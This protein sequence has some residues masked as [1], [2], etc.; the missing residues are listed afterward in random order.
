M[1]ERNSGSKGGSG[2]SHGCVPRTAGDRWGGRKS[3]KK[4]WILGSRREGGRRPI[5]LQ[6]KD[7]EMRSGCDSSWNPSSGY[8]ENVGC[9]RTWSSCHWDSEGF[10]PQ[11]CTSIHDP[12]TL[13]HSLL[14]SGS[15]CSGGCTDQYTTPLPA[16]GKT[17]PVKWCRV[18]VWSMRREQ[19]PV[20]LLWAGYPPLPRDWGWFNIFQLFHF[21]SSCLVFPPRASCLKLVCKHLREGIM[22]FICLSMHLVQSRRL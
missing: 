19:F 6:H 12:C 8:R 20:S 14:A 13:F 11:S 15:P 10:Y 7:P 2:G 4:A 21:P 1:G 9:L 16:V 18:K 5:V 3:R 17:T 22:F